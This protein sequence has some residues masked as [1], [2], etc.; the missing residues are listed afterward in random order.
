MK[1]KI[2]PKFVTIVMLSLMVLSV[3]LYM[4]E[5]SIDFFNSEFAQNESDFRGFIIVLFARLF[6]IVGWLSIILGLFL[7][8]QFKDVE[9]PKTDLLELHEKIEKMEK[10]K[11]MKKGA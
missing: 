7:R 5:K 9:K 4:I 11:L 8:G 3:G 10:E 1:L 2:T 6:M